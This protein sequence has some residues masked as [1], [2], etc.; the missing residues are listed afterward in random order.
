M[1]A[2]PLSL[3]PERLTQAP[4]GHDTL[5]RLE[6]ILMLQRAHAP[7]MAR[8]TAAERRDRL[9]RL[10]DAVVARRQA[11]YDA[12]WSDLHRP[13]AETELSELHITLVEIAHAIR[14]LPRWMRGRR[15]GT[16]L[17]VFGTSS[18]LVY[19][20]RGV[21]LILAPWNYPFH[22]VLNPLTSA[23]AAGC[24]AIVK[25]SEKAPVTTAV[26]RE[27][28]SATFPQEEVAL[29]EGGPDIAAAL[30]KEPF[31]HIHFTGG[32]AIG[33]RVM[34]AAAEHLCSLTLELG[35]K[36]PAIVDA[37]ADID[38]A[39]GRIVAGKFLN[40]GQTCIA[41]D[42]VLVHASRS[43]ALV[44][45]LRRALAAAYGADEA[46]RRASPDY[47]RIVDAMHFERIAELL[48]RT[49]AAGAG[50]AAGGETDAADRYVAPTILTDVRPGMPAMQE[51][52]FGP[53]LPI[54]TWEDEAEVVRIVRGLEKP[55]MLYVF[56]RDRAF[57]DRMV[58]RT[59]A[60]GTVI[61]NV[62]LHY[63]NHDAPF[64]GVGDS[65]MGACHGFAG[66][67]S[68]SHE[69]TVMRQGWLVTIPLFYAPYRGAR[70]RF[71]QWLLRTIQRI[72]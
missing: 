15:L 3:H 4:I 29:V 13:Q 30:L 44:A 35:G 21:A 7:V 45:A 49:V 72:G 17:T 62:G 37:T 52:I 41:P 40:A 63:L 23:I 54:V 20:P 18:R 31:D 46:A 55:L 59:A 69:R 27:L 70:S 51:E 71:A 33:R 56:T 19:E 8:T 38:A 1:T 25:P 6:H 66:F 24:C 57:A 50:I 53:L 22:L 68:F 16:S 32:T 34:V 67:R 43:A 61:N 28:I 39:A 64:G 58:A 26:L 60:G 48:H 65:G 11:V 12:L 47:G 5:T 42:Y 14:K 36:S 9:R 2:P 10:R